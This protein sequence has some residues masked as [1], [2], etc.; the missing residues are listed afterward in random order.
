MKQHKRL[1]DIEGTK[2]YEDLQKYIQEI[3]EE[4]FKSA[5]EKALDLQSEQ[6]EVLKKMMGSK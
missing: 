6:L 4:V 1:R 3:K 2:F 5:D